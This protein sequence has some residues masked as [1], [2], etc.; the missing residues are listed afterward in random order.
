MG[1]L[2]SSSSMFLVSTNSKY[3]IE[4]L[5]ICLMTL[6]YSRAVACRYSSQRCCCGAFSSCRKD[7]LLPLACALNTHAAG[8]EGKLLLSIMILTTFW[9]LVQVCTVSFGSRLSQRRSNRFFRQNYTLKLLACWDAPDK[10]TSWRL[11]VLI[12][13]TCVHG[14]RHHSSTVRMY[15]CTFTVPI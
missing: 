15:F 6:L 2:N 4:E 12:T 1:H 8:R 14:M 11:V 5:L 3:T 13:R 7:P 10:I 9:S